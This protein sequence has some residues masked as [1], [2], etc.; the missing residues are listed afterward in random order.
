[1]LASS[2][3]LLRDLAI[4]VPIEGLAVR[5]VG[6][7]MYSTSDTSGSSIT[8]LTSNILRRHI[9]W[10]GGIP[11]GKR[12]AVPGIYDWVNETDHQQ[13]DMAVCQPY[14]PIRSPQILF[15]LLNRAYG[16]VRPDGGIVLTT[17]PKSPELSSGDIRKWARAINT[18][19]IGITIDYDPT[20]R[21]TATQG[22]LR[23]TKHTGAPKNLPTINELPLLV[24]ERHIRRIVDQMRAGALREHDAAGGIEGDLIKFWLDNAIQNKPTSEGRTSNIVASDRLQVFEDKVNAASKAMEQKEPFPML[25]RPR[26]RLM[27][28]IGYRKGASLKFSGLTNR[29]DA[30]EIEFP[31]NGRVGCNI[32]F[33]SVDQRLLNYTTGLRFPKELTQE[34]VDVIEYCLDRHMALAARVPQKPEA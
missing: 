14:Y 7:P 6:H 24:T 4:R 10:E 33:A 23:I 29:G 3:K 5:A 8:R 32:Y 16:I 25:R 27:N 30:V 21:A 28:V 18:S 12:K 13:V 20:D 26:R 17:V 34:E 15:G 11:K 19:H 9:G 31:N 1:L 2:T 22:A